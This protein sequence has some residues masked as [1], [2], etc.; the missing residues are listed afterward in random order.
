MQLRE[1]VRGNTARFS[2]IHGGTLFYT[3]Q[4]GPEG[5]PNLAGTKEF[6]FPV[7][8]EELGGTLVNAEE[9]ASV[10]IKW[11]RKS[12]KDIESGNKCQRKGDV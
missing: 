2:H 11:I 12:L 10:F 6:T 3:I 7:P 4:E 1:L 8:V 9:R 5:G